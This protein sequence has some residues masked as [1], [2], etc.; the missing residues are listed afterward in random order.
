MRVVLVMLL[1]F[2][3]TDLLLGV[4]LL[5][6]VW[7]EHRRIRRD[8]AIAGE[9]LPTATGQLGC[10]LL[11]IVVGFGVVYGSIWLLLRE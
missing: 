9:V 4:G 3:L 11:L 5:V 2:A 1:V 10:L 8:A 6:F 7:V